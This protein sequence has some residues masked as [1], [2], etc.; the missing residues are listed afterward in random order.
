MRFPDELR[1]SRQ[2]FTKYGQTR[3]AIIFNV[4]VHCLLNIPVYIVYIAKYDLT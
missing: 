1:L 2:Y 3:T 4:P